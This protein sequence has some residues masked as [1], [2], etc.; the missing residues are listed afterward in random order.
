MSGGQLVNCVTLGGSAVGGT[1]EIT[2]SHL[3]ILPPTPW[4]WKHKVLWD[5]ES[6]PAAAELCGCA[7]PVI[8]APLLPPTAN[9]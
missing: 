5:L 4:L 7:V 1:M 9:P 3:L 6:P 2:D 8:P